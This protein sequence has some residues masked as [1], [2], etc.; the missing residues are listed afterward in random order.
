MRS[1]IR[2]RGTVYGLCAQG[3]AR[4]S[5]CLILSFCGRG[6]SDLSE[7]TLSVIAFCDSTGCQAALETVTGGVSSSGISGHM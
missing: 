2:I 5:D 4:L 7:V 3:N 1:T 6:R